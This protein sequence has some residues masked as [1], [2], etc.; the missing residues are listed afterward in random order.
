MLHL[1]P[2]TV[3]ME[4]AERHVPEAL[5]ANEHVRFG[6]SVPFG[7]L[8][9]DFGPSGV[10]GDPTQASA[11]DGATLFDAIVTRVV[12]ALREVAAFDLA[13]LRT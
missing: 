13:D 2:D 12:A 1:R 8:S 7:W 9:D 6:G 11:A 3:V 10:I 4:R 5:A